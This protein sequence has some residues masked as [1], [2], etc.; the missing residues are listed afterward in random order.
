MMNFFKAMPTWQLV[1][2]TVLLVILLW[3]LIN[4]LYYKLL[5]K[6]L[7]GELS[8]SD[9]EATMRKA[10]I[11][12]LRNKNAFDGTH[13]L[14]ARNINYPMLKQTSTELRKDLPVYL[15]D[16]TDALSIRAARLLKKQGFKDV[17]WL[18]KGFNAWTGKTKQSKH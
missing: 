15:Y 1:L 17:K 10:Q 6:N 3:L 4:W 2:N 14:G 7:G 12:D 8:Q 13:I 18:K 11:I 16:E 5:K 9:F